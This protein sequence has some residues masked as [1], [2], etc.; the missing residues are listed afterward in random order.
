MTKVR[1]EKKGRECWENYLIVFKYVLSEEVTSVQRLEGSE[2][3]KIY[4]KIHRERILQK[5]AY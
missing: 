2:G 1:R 4:V 5:E 3:K